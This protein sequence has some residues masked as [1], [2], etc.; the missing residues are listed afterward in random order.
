[1][2]L[3][4]SRHFPIAFKRKEN[5]EPPSPDCPASLN[6]DLRSVISKSNSPKKL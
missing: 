1:M 2:E 4:S 6:A 5:R 3:N